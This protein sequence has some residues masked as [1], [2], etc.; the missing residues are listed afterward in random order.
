M[1]VAI[2]GIVSTVRVLSSAEKPREQSNEEDTETRHT[3]ADNADVDFDCRPDRDG[4][5]VPGWV[6]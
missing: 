2:S 1:T 6:D 3:G 4:Q 5:I